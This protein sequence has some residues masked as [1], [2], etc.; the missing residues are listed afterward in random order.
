[1]SPRKPSEAKHYSIRLNPSYEPGDVELYRIIEQYRAQ[2]YTFKEIVRAALLTEAGFD[3]AQYSSRLQT[4]A[5]VASME[6]LLAEF[7]E[8]I[9]KE[10]NT[11]VSAGRR[12]S[13]RRDY[14]DDDREGDDDDVPSPEALNFARGFVRRQQ[15]GGRR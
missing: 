11:G 6:S 3:P 12:T 8:H 15:S 7:A 2:G 13:R 9:I 10:L 1:M 4:G 5:I 14:E